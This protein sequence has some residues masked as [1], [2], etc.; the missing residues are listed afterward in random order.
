[1][2]YME[3]KKQGGAWRTDDGSK[4]QLAIPGTAPARTSWQ[5]PPP[6][7]YKLNFDAAIFS[8]LNCSGFGAI[9]RNQE[10]EVT[11][12]MSVKGPFVHNSVEAEAWRVGELLSFPLKLVSQGWPLKGIMH[13]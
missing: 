2:A 12:G 13:W 4:V 1:M 7:V 3:S 8:D 9:I 6:S 10:G 5:P 11:V